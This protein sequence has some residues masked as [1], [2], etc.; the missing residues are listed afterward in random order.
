MYILYIYVPMKGIIVVTDFYQ[1]ERV[2]HIGGC[3]RY[4]M[5]LAYGGYLYIESILSC[6]VY[7][8]KLARI[9][10]N[11]KQTIL[12]KIAKIITQ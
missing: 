11:H 1:T 7:A 3:R 4:L 9:C 10:C 5:T 6:Y 2:P 12:Q 8:D